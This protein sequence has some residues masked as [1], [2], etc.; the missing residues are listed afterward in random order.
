M[1]F[2]KNLI[3]TKQLGN[4]CQKSCHQNFKKMS[5]L[6][7]LIESYFRLKFTAVMSN[8]IFPA[9]RSQSRSSRL[10]ISLSPSLSL[11]VCS[12]LYVCLSFLYIHMITW[13]S[14]VIL[15]DNAF[16]LTLITFDFYDATLVIYV[17]AQPKY[18]PTL[19]TTQAIM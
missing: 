2:K 9:A 3:V 6:V 7:T 5:N 14:C 1:F 13:C 4:F 12:I 19:T 11:Y 15:A 18:L 10:T 8:G 16:A 17:Y